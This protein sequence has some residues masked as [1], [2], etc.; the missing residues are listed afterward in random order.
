MTSKEKTHEVKRNVIDKKIKHLI[1]YAEKLHSNIFEVY[2]DFSE[3]KCETIVGEELG[4][5]YKN[6]VFNKYY[7][8]KTPFTISDNTID[9]YDITEMG[10]LDFYKDK[11][12]EFDKKLLNL[13]RENKPSKIY[14][15]KPLQFVGYCLE[16][17][18]FEYILGWE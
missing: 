3:I 12:K 13:W 7:L 14:I 2:V 4:K 17:F 16:R 6:V 1:D 5:N 10:L 11:I 15:I 18:E 9:F 8:P